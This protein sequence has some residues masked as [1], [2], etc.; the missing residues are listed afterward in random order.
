MP[1]P[2]LGLTLPARI[3]SVIDGDTVRG[4]ARVAFTLRLCGDGEKQCWAP[5][6]KEP[7]G[8]ES[9]QNL[10]REAT[11]KDGTLHIPMADDIDNISALFSLG[12]VLGDFWID[13]NGESLSQHQVRS[14]HAASRKG[15]TL[16][17]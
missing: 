6:L 9:K 7:G 14:G 8:Q 4:E 11:G 12:R 2:P 13:G 16:G 15:G 3:T 5:E 1:A 10:A 17:R